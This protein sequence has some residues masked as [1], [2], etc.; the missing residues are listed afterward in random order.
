MTREQMIDADGR[1]KRWARSTLYRAIRVGK[2]KRP[3]S[4]EECGCDP[5]RR[6]DGRT[7]LHGHHHR[8]YHRPLD[9][10]WLCIKCHF[11]IDRRP[12]GEA[13][14]RA[15]LTANQV[16]AIRNSEV[17]TK[18]LVAQYGVSRT[19]VQKIRAGTQW[20]H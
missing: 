7:L 13:N 4:C 6:S 14:G 20:A 9:V 2:I 5:G 3:A 11:A 1:L 19:T 18:H 12:A 16:A 10:Q 17:Q 8:G 15:K